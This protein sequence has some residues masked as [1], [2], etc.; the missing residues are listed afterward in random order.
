MYAC[1]SPHFFLP[2]T[3][4]CLLARIPAAIGTLNWLVIFNAVPDTRPVYVVGEVF[5]LLWG[6]NG[7]IWG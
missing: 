4:D 6:T 5:A 2:G 3:D 7:F 1:Q